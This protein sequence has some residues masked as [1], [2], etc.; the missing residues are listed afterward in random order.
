MRGTEVRMVVVFLLMAFACHF[1]NLKSTLL[2]FVKFIR[3]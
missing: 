3:F 1:W 2:S